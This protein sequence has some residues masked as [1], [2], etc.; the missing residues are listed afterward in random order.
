M[1][2]SP[3]IPSIDQLIAMLGPL[4]T[5]V[6]FILGFAF[7][8]LIGGMIMVQ[9][10]NRSSR[11]PYKIDWKNRHLGG[12][13]KRTPYSVLILMQRGGSVSEV[14]DKWGYIDLQGEQSAFYK[15]LEWTSA[16]PPFT[17]MMPGRFFI[18][19]SPADNE[20]VPLDLTEVSNIRP[21]VNWKA[22]G[23]VINRMRANHEAFTTR[24]DWEKVAPYVALGII[25]F[26]FVGVM[27]FTLYFLSDK[28]DHA[29]ALGSQII[30][31]AKT[32][33]SRIPPP[34]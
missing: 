8:L 27:F 2:I 20:I 24:S 28:L 22:Q 26:A 11:V 32:C 9:M 16:V 21:S 10:I 30:E 19:G 29:I 1:Q 34:A 23:H 31:A 33:P 15:F 7:F 17:A 6:A 5:G 13:I 14:W 18:A 25:A 3:Q 4:G 12:L